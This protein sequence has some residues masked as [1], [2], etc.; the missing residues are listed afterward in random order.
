MRLS[1]VTPLTPSTG[2]VVHPSTKGKSSALSKR[3][4]CGLPD[5]I[6]LINERRVVEGDGRVPTHY[7]C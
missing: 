3:L 5:E 7:R 4:R 6:A 1:P 2:E